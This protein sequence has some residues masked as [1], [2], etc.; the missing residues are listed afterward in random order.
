MK[1]YIVKMWNMVAKSE[2]FFYEEGYFIVKFYNAEDGD[3][4]V[5]LSL[6]IM[7]SKFIVL[8]VQIFEFDFEEEFMRY[9]L[10]QVKFFNLSV[11]CWRVNF[12]S[13][14]VS[15]L[16]IFIFADEYTVKKIRIFFIRVLVEIDVIQDI[17]N[18]IDIVDFL[19]RIFTEKV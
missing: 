19:G 9:F 4:V 14:I 6:Y 8:R 2:L 18:E 16:G 17:F 13:R 12:L 15:R 5:Y 11:N 1:G 10:I 7:N 3:D